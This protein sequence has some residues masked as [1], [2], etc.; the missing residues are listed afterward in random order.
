MH[1]YRWFSVIIYMMF[2]FVVAV[3][4]LNLLIAQFSKSYEE[5]TERARVSVALDRA[6]ILSRLQSSLWI[7]A[8]VSE[9]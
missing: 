7:R 3:I 5:V 4:L 9:L 2:L 6:R 8:Y 1:V